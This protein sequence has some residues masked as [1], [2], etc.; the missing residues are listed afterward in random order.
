MGAY[1]APVLLIA[2]IVWFASTNA[3]AM[4]AVIVAACPCALVLAAPATAIAGIAVG[5][6]HGVLFKNAAFLDKMAELDSLII[7][8]TGTLTHGELSVTKVW[9]EPGVDAD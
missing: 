7:D 4:L 5:A 3:S 9:T 8:K 1:L 2:A 6:R